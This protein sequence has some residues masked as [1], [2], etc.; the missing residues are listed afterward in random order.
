MP[1]RANQLTAAI[2]KL[3]RLKGAVVTRTNNAPALVV[4]K[5]QGA[6]VTGTY[7]KPSRDTFTPGWPDITGVLPG[8]QMI[9]VEVKTPNDRLSDEQ[10]HLLK[11]MRARGAIVVVASS[12]D[13]VLAALPE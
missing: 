5:R 7:R 2:I 1:S 11:Q 6:T 13:D 3:L 10:R 8:G 12:V 4:H 9:A